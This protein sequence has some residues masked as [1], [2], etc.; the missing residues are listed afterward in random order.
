[1]Q[2]D[3]DKIVTRMDGWIAVYHGGPYIDVHHER[4]PD[5]ALDCINVWDY[6]TD[7]ATIGF[8]RVAVRIELAEWIEESAADVI[9][10]QLPYI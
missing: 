8:D 10:H 1:M 4:K 5:Y 2:S 7:K 9:E 6:E 3:K